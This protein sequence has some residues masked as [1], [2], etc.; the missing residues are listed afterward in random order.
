MSYVDHKFLRMLSPQLDK[1]K[2]KS[3]QVYNFRCPLCGDS[4]K[5][6][7]KARGYAFEHKG[8]LLYKCHNCG[9]SI[10]VGKLIE[11][12]DPTLY[13]EYAL[14]KFKNS[15]SHTIKSIDNQKRAFD[16]HSFS[17]PKFDHSKQLLQEIGA[18]LVSSLPTTHIARKFLERRMIPLGTDF[19]YIDDEELLEKMSDKYVER[20][21]GHSSRLL[22]PFYDQFNKMI[23]ITGR[24][25]DNRRTPKYLT[26]KF[27]DDSEP[28]F[29]GLNTIDQRKTIFVVEG[30]IDSLFIPNGL[31]VAGSDFNKLDKIIPKS[32]CVI[33]FDNEPRNKDIIKKMRNLVDLGYK[34]CVW[35]EH[36]EEKDIN[37]MVISGKTVEYISSTIN[38]N[39]FKDLGA[40]IAIQN[41]KKI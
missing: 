10:S 34:I 28:L 17:P 39:T 27:N 38:K 3:E 41:W 13:K 21:A 9:I 18:K 23:G 6:K 32:K 33:I 4:S 37:D 22:I 5:S 29:F 16:E 26:L 12:I 30:P 2:K 8:A 24:V 1:F 25:I 7:T 36:I 20:I 35:P 31:A 40:Q 15:T 19:Y 14:E 11:T